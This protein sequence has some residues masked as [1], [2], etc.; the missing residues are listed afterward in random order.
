[1]RKWIEMRVGDQEVLRRLPPNLGRELYSADMLAMAR[2]SRPDLVGG[3][4]RIDLPADSPTWE[5]VL[6]VVRDVHG[7]AY[8]HYSAW[9][10]FRYAKQELLSAEVLRLQIIRAF[11]PVGEQCGTVYDES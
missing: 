8:S 9:V 6:G 7:E 5:Q 10:H 1:M 3:V 2:I 4:R 11:E